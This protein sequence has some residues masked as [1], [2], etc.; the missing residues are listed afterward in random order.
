MSL[1]GG[2]QWEATESEMQAQ[3]LSD[4]LYVKIKRGMEVIQNAPSLL[5]RRHKI[6]YCVS[7]LHFIPS[8]YGPLSFPRQRVHQLWI[9]VGLLEVTRFSV[10]PNMFLG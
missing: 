7:S 3:K 5:F 8:E 10:H 9:P 4:W 2:R 6:F 1:W